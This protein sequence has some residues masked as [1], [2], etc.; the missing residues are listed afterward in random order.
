MRIHILCN[1]GSPLGVTSKTMWGDE[2]RIGLGG[3]EQALITMCEEWTKVGHEVVLFNDPHKYGD[4]PFEQRA[5]AAF[6]PGEDRDVLIVFRSTNPRVLVS[7]GLKV[8]WSTDQSSTGNYKEFAPLV[9]KIVCISPYHQKYFAETYGITNT[10]Y[11]DL[12]VRVDDYKDKN[13]EKIPYRII[14]TSV[15][16]RGLNN[17]CRMYPALK[18]RIP[19]LSLVI[20]SDYR[21]WGMH[22]GGNEKFRPMWVSYEGVDYVG[23]VLREQLIQEELSAEAMLYPCNYEELF[24]ISVAEAQ[25]AGAYPITSSIG[26]LGTTNMGTP[27]K[28]DP[29]NPH[30]D[31]TFITALVDLFEDRT[32]LQTLQK[33]IAEKAYNRFRPEVILKQ[34]DKVFEE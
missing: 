33:E 31:I 29:N 8:W 6:N 14:F 32:K 27:I 17:L 5:I 13:Y 7:K 16:S 28:I 1:D 12:P 23:A 2:F 4:S 30:D 10:V 19:E 22:A 11:I 9:D 34:W 20:T 24:C 18:K 3:A 26:A 25:F 21:L 15:P